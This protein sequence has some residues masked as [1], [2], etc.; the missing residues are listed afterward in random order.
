MQDVDRIAH[1]K[2][3][4]GPPRHR[5][6]R[7]QVESFGFILGPEHIH[8]IVGQC[9]N[10]WDLGQQPAVRAAELQLAIRLSLDLVA[11]LMDRAW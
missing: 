3:L 10:R 2:V 1:V 7:V 6:P 4:S 9:W 11:L 8:G 5:R